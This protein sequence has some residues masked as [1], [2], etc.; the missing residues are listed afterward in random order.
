MQLTASL[1]WIQQPHWSLLI[2]LTF[3]VSLPWTPSRIHPPMPQQPSGHRLLEL[4][5][6][7]FMK[8]CSRT[9]RTPSSLGIL[10]DIVSTL[11]GMSFVINLG[12][13]F[14]SFLFRLNKIWHFRRLIWCLNITDTAKVYGTLMWGSVGSFT[15][16]MMLFQDTLFRWVKDIFT[17]AQFVSRKRKIFYCKNFLNF[18]AFLYL[19]NLVDENIFFDKKNCYKIFFLG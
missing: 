3:L 4:H 11:S 18:L 15:I 17:N 9:Q 2:G 7:I 1:M 6:M 5:F 13:P 14:Q 19:K 12:S 16:W 10:M 8:L